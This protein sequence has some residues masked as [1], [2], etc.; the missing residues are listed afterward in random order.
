[1]ARPPSSGLNRRRHP[2]L[3]RPGPS[4]G[5]VR[6]SLLGS[7]GSFRNT[8][9]GER[10][11][12]YAA[13]TCSS[14]TNGDSS[15]SSNGTTSRTTRSHEFPVHPLD[16]QDTQHTAANPE[17]SSAIREAG[18]MRRSGGDRVASSTARSS[19]L[20]ALLSEPVSERLVRHWAQPALPARC[21]CC[22]GISRKEAK[23]DGGRELCLWPPPQAVTQSLRECSLHERPA[24]P[25]RAVRF[26]A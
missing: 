10:P 12:S 14:P 7:G 9:P 19:F 4:H 6:A 1:M 17:R 2:Q 21:R 23:S 22:P 5:P 25:S 15:S 8:G 26:S 16:T 13:S 11:L 24:T 20:I 18:S 3:L